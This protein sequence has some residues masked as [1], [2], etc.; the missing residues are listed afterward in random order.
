MD[1]VTNPNLMRIEH[2]PLEQ[3]IEASKLLKQFLTE[4]I[5]DITK[6]SIEQLINSLNSTQIPKPGSYEELIHYTKVL[7]I[8]RNQ[9]V[10]KT[11]PHLRDLFK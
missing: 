5:H 4:D 3:R 11:F 1:P 6:H 10:K 8:K 9:N 7:D 2:V